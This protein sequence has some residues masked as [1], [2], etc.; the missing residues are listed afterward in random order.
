MAAGPKPVLTDFGLSHLQDSTSTFES[1]TDGCKGTL[2]Y[3]AIELFGADD[4]SIKNE[5]TV[6]S[7][8]WAFGMVGQVSTS[9]FRRS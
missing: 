9:F 6:Y 4:E 3:M 2:R 7:D 5:H 1:A 8:V